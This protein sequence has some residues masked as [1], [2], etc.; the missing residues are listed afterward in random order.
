M[1]EASRPFDRLRDREASGLALSLLAFAI[2]VT[3]LVLFTD[4]TP[5][6]VTA[7][8]S[9]STTADPSSPIRRAF[10][11]LTGRRPVARR[12]Q[13]TETHLCDVPGVA[14]PEMQHRHVTS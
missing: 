8:R 7:R 10:A 12:R 2:V 11:F 14:T 1:R 5:P 13:H 9:R 4:R 3:K 6:R